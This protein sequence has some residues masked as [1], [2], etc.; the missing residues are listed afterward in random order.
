MQLEALGSDW[1]ELAVA[2]ARPY[3]APGWL[4]SWWRAAAPADAE[5]RTVVVRSGHE[6][7]GL[8]PFFASQAPAGLSLRP[9]GAGTCTRVE[10]LARAGRE[11]E[12]AAV[13]APLLAETGAELLTLEGVPAGSP[14]PELLAEAWPARAAWLH[15][16]ERMPSPTVE[17]AARS[18]DEWFAAKSSNFRQYI[19]RFGRRLQDRGAHIELVD[20]D[21]AMSGA[22][23]AFAEL[24]RAR[25]ADRGGSGVLRDGVEQAVAGA[26]RLLPPDRFRLF[27]ASAEGQPVAASLFLAAGGEVTYW[28]GGFDDAWADTR[29]QMH[30]ILAAIEHAMGSGDRRVD[31]GAGGQDYKY[32]FADGEE[33]LR[34]VTLV[35]P[36][37]GRLKTRLRLLPGQARLELAQRLSPRQKARLKRLL[38]RS[39]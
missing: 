25:W 39:P 4:L 18:F 20:G 31:L 1:D 15:E 14:W 5:L 2:S 22:V 9:L 28:L 34:W 30:V 8:A 3:C 24:H 10:P 23:S 13:A 37:R 26:A 38:R 12:V 29:P 11:R 7:V 32:R 21:Q 6:L 27:L 16:D 17:V 19:R 35:P 33:I 36:G